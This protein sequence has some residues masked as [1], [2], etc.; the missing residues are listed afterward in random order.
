MEKKSITNSKFIITSADTDMEA[1]LRLS[2]IINIL[3]QSASQSAESLGFGYKN[4]KKHKLFWVLSRLSIEILET[5]KWNDEIIVETWPKDINGILYLRD[6]FLRNRNKTTIAKATT[7]WLAI[8][9][10]SK[11]PKRVA[12]ENR[13]LFI[14][15]KDKFA[16]KDPPEKLS[17]LNSGDKFEINSNYFDIDLNKHVTSTR[18]IDW[19]MDT[20]PI[21]FHKHNYPEKLSVNYVK[22]TLP[23]QKI[24]IKRSEIKKN[25]YIFEGVDNKSLKTS[26]RGRIDFKNE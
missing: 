14:S 23:G 10:E 2:A 12:E 13:E 11:R 19:M 8:D 20:F 5:V 7:G 1:R 24:S 21:D 25:E 15:L 18:Y 17:P 4:L 26:F 16:I 6:F 3:I 22:E 9:L